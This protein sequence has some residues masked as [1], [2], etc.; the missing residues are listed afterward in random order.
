VLHHD[1]ELVTGPAWLLW[2]EPASFPL[3][4]ALEPQPS[5]LW[6][7]LDVSVDEVGVAAVV[8]EAPPLPKAATASQAARNV[9][10]TAAVTRR[11]MVRR[12]WLMGA[13]GGC[14]MRRIVARFAQI[15][16]G[17]WYGA[18]KNRQSVRQG[19]S[20]VT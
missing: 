1:C 5:S 15:L 14:C 20:K 10:S 13:S 3:C 8:L 17:A 18:G 6:L 4:A 16:L 12:R 9:A 7:E 11:R 19:A 2:L